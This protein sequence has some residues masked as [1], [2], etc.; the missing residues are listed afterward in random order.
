VDFPDLLKKLE[1]FGKKFDNGVENLARL[2]LHPEKLWTGLSSGLSKF[3]HQVG[4]HLGGG[5]GLPQPQGGSQGGGAPNLWEI[6][7]RAN[8]NPQ[9]PPDPSYFKKLLEGFGKAMQATPTERRQLRG[10]EKERANAESEVELSQ[11]KVKHA[12]KWLARAQLI[13]PEQTKSAQES[14]EHHLIG[15]DEAKSKAKNA[16]DNYA[17]AQRSQSTF[18]KMAG[19]LATGAEFATQAGFGGIGGYLTKQATFAQ[20]A[21]GDPMA[22]ARSAGIAIGGVRGAAKAGVGAATSEHADEAFAGVFKGL[23]KFSDA[24]GP[25]G[26]PLK[27]VGMLGEAVFGTVGSIREWGDHLHQANMQ[28][29]E[30]S[31]GMA[32]IQAQQT[33]ADIEYSQRR[34]DARA[35]SAGV[36][37][38][39]RNVTRSTWAPL[40][41]AFADFKNNLGAKLLSIID[42]IGSGVKAILDFLHIHLPQE[43]A[44]PESTR[45]ALMRQ[46]QELQDFG[47]GGEED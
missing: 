16:R 3:S 43:E 47:L 44:L 25:A 22:I 1:D 29:A 24:L 30:F 41:D 7:R 10:A 36:L 37:A 32:A 40:E 18:G 9:P 13:S 2:F 33:A 42:D 11:K 6:L 14:L 4:Q 19:K 8:P 5:S 28:F 17:Q 46:M 12:Q 31:G 26:L 45:E 34:G 38:N 35:A 15:L 39:Q 23:D 27:A 21:T 20:A